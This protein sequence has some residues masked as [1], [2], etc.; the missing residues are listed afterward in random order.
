MATHS[1]LLAGEIPWTE[2]PGRLW[3]MGSKRVGQYL[4]TKQQFVKY[5]SYIIYNLHQ[6]YLDA[7]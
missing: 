6:N 5:K 2:E 7:F 4:A 3:P 1:S